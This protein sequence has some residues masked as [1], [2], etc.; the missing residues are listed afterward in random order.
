M[1]PSPLIIAVSISAVFL[2]FGM[3]LTVSIVGFYEGWRIG[4]AYAR[5]RR[6]S[7]ILYEG[8]T[9]KLGNRLIQKGL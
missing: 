6:F 5:G 7:A 2:A 1:T 4:W 8:P 3:M 9:M